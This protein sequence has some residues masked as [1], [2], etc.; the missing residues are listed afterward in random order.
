MVCLKIIK[1]LT[2]CSHI[3][4]GFSTFSGDSRDLLSLRKLPA[5][6]SLGMLVDVIFKNCLAKMDR[7]L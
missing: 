2:I 5:E 6:L 3:E 1:C 4:R 7:N